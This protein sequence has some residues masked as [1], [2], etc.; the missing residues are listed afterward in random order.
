VSLS[1]AKVMTSYLGGR[2]RP[3]PI[4]VGASISLAVNVVSNFL[5]IPPLGI[6]GASLSS[7]VSYTALAV[8]MVFAASR[9]SGQSIVALCVPRPAEFK[10]LVAAASRI[11]GQV[12]AR[13]GRTLKAAR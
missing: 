7:V 6:V 2:G 9:V 4:S 1:V 10:I 11:A 12:A 8:M 3:G 13:A 5:L